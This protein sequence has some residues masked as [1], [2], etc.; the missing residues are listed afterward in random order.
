MHP[1]IINGSSDTAIILPTSVLHNQTAQ[2]GFPVSVST[3]PPIRV[4]PQAVAGSSGVIDDAASGE[5]FP[6]RTSRLNA[7]E[8]SSVEGLPRDDG[9]S[10]YPSKKDAIRK[11]EAMGVSPTTETAFRIKKTNWDGRRDSPISN[12]PNGI[13]TVP[14]IKIHDN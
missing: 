8:G 4:D 2:H 5:G 12:F 13:I 11:Y 10:E 1:D 14:K 6:E 9:G 7:P 3:E